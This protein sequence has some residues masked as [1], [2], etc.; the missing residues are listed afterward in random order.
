MAELSPFGG[1]QMPLSPDA[2]ATC[3]MSPLQGV[4]PPTRRAAGDGPPGVPPSDAPH[5]GHGPPALPR[6]S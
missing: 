3:A 5:S 6:R 2:A 1:V 4:T